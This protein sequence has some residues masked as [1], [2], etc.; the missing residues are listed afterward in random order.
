MP[1]DEARARPRAS[2]SAW[3][4]AVAFFGAL[5]TSTAVAVAVIT[6]IS[7]AVGIYYFSPWSRSP[8]QPP[9][10]LDVNLTTR[11]LAE[12]PL[13]HATR[14]ELARYYLQWGLAVSRSQM[15]IDELVT[16]SELIDYFEGRLVEW[17]RLGEDVTA[18]REMLKRD[19]AGFRNRFVSEERSLSRGMFE[20]SI[21][22]FRQT[23]ALGAML[24]ARD[25]YDLGTAY[26][27]LGPEGYEGADKFL[28][29]AVARG[30][31]S[32]RA[33]TFLGNVSVAR[34][35]LEEG[36]ALYRR[37]LEYAP[38]DP[39]LAFNLALAYKERGQYAPAVD[40]LRATLRL[41]QD[42]ENLIEDE[43]SIILQARLALGWC[44]LKQERFPEAVEQFEIVLEGQPDLA[45]A[46]YW[47]GVNYEGL[48][49][50]EM[51]KVHLQRALRLQPGLRDAAERLAAIERSLSPRGGAARRGAPAR[52]A[53]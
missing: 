50:P 28:G 21:L 5:D 32:A 49:R 30:L 45:E 18:L 33:L 20:Q 39:I 24:S 27:Q 3:G 16:D 9:P 48:G 7:C 38:D 41:Y 13:D 47:L 40:F 36:I 8:A 11:R 10:A 43:L 34:G 53:R 52:R 44:L 51:A 29:E 25:L 14:L 42:R 35:D 2:R 26:Y 12:D 1:Q 23:R 6:G 4:R 37:A 17:E 19:F 46:H 31:V 15:P 22:L